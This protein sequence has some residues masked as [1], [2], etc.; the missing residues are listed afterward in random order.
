[1][2]VAR[3]L[4]GKATK[5]KIMNIIISLQNIISPRRGVGFAIIGLGLSL[6]RNRS[7]SGF[8]NTEKHGSEGLI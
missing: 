1:V 7:K 4:F 2:S 3:P 6:Q 5:K 8:Q